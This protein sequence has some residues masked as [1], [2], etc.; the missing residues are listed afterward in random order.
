M[1]EGQYIA[2]RSYMEEHSSLLRQILEEVK[3]QKA[4][5]QATAQTGPLVT[6]ASGTVERAAP[7]V[8][9]DAVGPVTVETVQTIDSGKTGTVVKKA[10]K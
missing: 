3:G 10:G 5:P 8:P 4:A 2:L 9:P 6:D 1:N 7:K